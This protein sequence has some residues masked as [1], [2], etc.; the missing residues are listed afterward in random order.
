MITALSAYKAMIEAS[1]SGKNG[2][3]VKDKIG[4][5][6]A[7]ESA[8]AVSQRT[9]N[10]ERPKPSDADFV[11]I[12]ASQDVFTAVDSFFNLGKSNRFDDFHSLSSEDKETFIKIVADLAKSG[13][14]GYEELLVNNKI[15]RHDIVN[16]IGDERI[17][18]AKVYDEY[19]KTTR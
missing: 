3:G 7:S 2:P 9:E 4:A 11:D 16:K 5:A 6:S 18:G 14:M 8:T 10:V 19:T 1:A 17:R 13:Y 12:S 15:E